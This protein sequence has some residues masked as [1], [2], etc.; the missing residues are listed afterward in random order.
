MPK[1]VNIIRYLIWYYDLFIHIMILWKLYYC[2][3]LH[4]KKNLRNLV[5]PHL[6]AH[7]VAILTSILNSLLSFNSFKILNISGYQFWWSSPGQSW[8]CYWAGCSWLPPGRPPCR[9]RTWMT[10]LKRANRCQ[11]HQH[12]TSSF[13]IQSFLQSF[14]PLT[15]WL[16]YFLVK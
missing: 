12:F 11:F 7:K 5:M 14:S 16:C 13:F 15:V 4:W 3:T 2:K 8:R 9:W 1:T 10:R 6:K